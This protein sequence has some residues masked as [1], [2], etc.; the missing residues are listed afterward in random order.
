MS[1]EW[2]DR[3]LKANLL[4]IPDKVDRAITATMARHATKAV[5]YARKNASW[6]D[7]T[8]NA[9]NGLFSL[10][11]KEGHTYRIIVAHSMPYGIWLE[12]R[13]SGKYAIIR[14]TIDR[15]GPA[16]MKT[17]SKMFG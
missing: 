5:A 4:E 16:I 8:S 13:W 14:P 1:F 11:E 3:E 15:E 12:V 7:R 9:R 2:D 6:K 17:L 10:S